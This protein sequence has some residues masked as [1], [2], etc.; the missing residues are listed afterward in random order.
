LRAYYL[1]VG[2]VD[3][4]LD[5]GRLEAGRD[6]L[7]QL[8]DSRPRFGAETNGSRA[9]LVTEVLKCHISPEVYP[10][11]R[12]KLA[13]LYEA[14]VGERES[15]TLRAFMEHRQAVGRLTADVSYLLIRPLLEG[16]RAD[17]WRFLQQVGAVGCLIDSAIDLSA[18][19]REGLLRFRP[20]LKCR[21]VL[22]DRIVRAGLKLLCAHPR[23]SGL[24]LEAV[25]DDL[26][27]RLRA[28]ATA[29]RVQV[30]RAVER[31]ATL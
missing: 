15:E 31:A 17:L 23:L 21:L 12:A 13:A 1:F 16:E 20:T 19:A 26:F 18:D 29:A 2:V 27:D 5:A 22:T 9:R 3:D 24:F 10:L 30:A 25:G 4:A 11:V 7:R 14:V 6:I 8:D 28:R